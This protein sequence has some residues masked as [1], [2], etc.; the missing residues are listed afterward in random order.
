MAKQPGKKF[1]TEKCFQSQ[2]L[3]KRDVT[4]I[5]AVV[6]KHQA[7]KP[8]S[9]VILGHKI[10]NSLQEAILSL[11][12][13]LGCNTLSKVFPINPIS[14]PCFA[15]FGLSLPSLF[16]QVSFSKT[17]MCQWIP[18]QDSELQY[19]HNTGFSTITLN[20]LSAVES[21]GRLRV[22]PQYSRSCSRLRVACRRLRNVTTKS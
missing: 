13:Y 12:T 15:V 5:P 16:Q 6:T 14:L 11:L 8:L 7:R 17:S 10:G 22:P 20:T 19:A 1:K 21:L 9:Q 2:P 3:S 18:P 4:H